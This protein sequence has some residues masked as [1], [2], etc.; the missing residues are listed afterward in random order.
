MV[1]EIIIL[2]SAD[3]KVEFVLNA[4]E[5]VPMIKADAVSIR[6]LLHNILKNAMEAMA[7]QGVITVKIYALS[8]R[9]GTVVR[10][11]VYDTGCGVDMQ[12]AHKIFEPYVTNK[13]KGTGLGLAIVKKIVEEHGGAIR[14]D[15]Q[16]QQGA[17][18]IIEFPAVNI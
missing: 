15:S 4:D 7:G 3:P 14:V 16:Y 17:G 9:G 12:Q 11:A 2:Y 6:Q 18:F 5:P 1:Q 13:T 10:L 8:K